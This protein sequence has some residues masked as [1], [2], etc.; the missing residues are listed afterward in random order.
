MMDDMGGMDATGDICSV[1]E[2]GA[3]GANC[4]ARSIVYT[5]TCRV[6]HCADV[7][8]HSDVDSHVNERNDVIFRASRQNRGL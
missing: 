8:R 2:G 7:G 3:G 1:R 5:Y 6:W 4:S